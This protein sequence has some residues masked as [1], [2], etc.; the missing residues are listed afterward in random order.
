MFLCATLTPLK[1]SIFGSVAHIL[2]FSHSLHIAHV[3][4]FAHVAVIVL[5]LHVESVLNLAHV[6]QCRHLCVAYLYNGTGGV[7][8]TTSVPKSVLRY[9]SG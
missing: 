4:I 7:N 1:Q 9:V 5:L 3:V 6:V 2:R 8:G